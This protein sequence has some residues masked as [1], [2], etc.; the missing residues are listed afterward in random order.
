MIAGTLVPPSDTR[1]Q[2]RGVDN[3]AGSGGGSGVLLD[4]EASPALP[5]DSGHQLS[6]PQPISG[7]HVVGGGGGGGDAQTLMRELAAGRPGVERIAPFLPTHVD[8]RLISVCAQ[9]FK[10]M[11]RHAVVMERV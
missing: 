10:G 5:L 9:E 3:D 2:A 1:A 4:N 6:T 11:S 8:L 7:G